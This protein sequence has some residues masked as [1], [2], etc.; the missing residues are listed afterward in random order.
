MEV[1][2]LLTL[3]LPHEDS[4]LLELDN[5][6]PRLQALLHLAQLGELFLLFLSNG[7]R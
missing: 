1:V 7:R 2:I 3:L 5:A 4:M 6:S